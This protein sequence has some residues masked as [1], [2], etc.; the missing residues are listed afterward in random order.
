LLSRGYEDAHR[1][2]V[3]P[4]VGASGEALAASVEPGAGARSPG[5]A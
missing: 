3:D 4:I 2:F 5:V 1:Q